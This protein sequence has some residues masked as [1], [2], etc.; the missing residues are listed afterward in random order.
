MEPFDRW[1]GTGGEAGLVR[2]EMA[3]RDLGHF[4]VWHS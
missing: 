1:S 2:V 4:N 3:T